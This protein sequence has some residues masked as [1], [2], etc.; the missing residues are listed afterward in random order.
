MFRWVLKRLAAEGLVSGKNLGVDATTL[1]ANAALKSI[2]RRDDGASYDE[3]VTA[4]MKTEGVE[5]P[6]PSA[7]VLTASARSRWRTGTG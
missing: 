6:T 5:E 4:L 3:H 1:E 7:S 2:V